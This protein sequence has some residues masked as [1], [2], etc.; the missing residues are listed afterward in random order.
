VLA[1]LVT[2]IPASALGKTHSL[3]P[4]VSIVPSG[5]KLAVHIA[6]QPQAGCKL[7]A[8]AKHKSAT[9]PVVYATRRGKAVIVWTVPTDAPSGN[10]VFRVACKKGR[11]THRTTVKLL[12]INH[13]RGHGSLLVPGSGE[14]GQGT[15]GL[16]GKGGGSGQT[17][18]PDLNG[19]TVCF[20]NDPFGYYQGGTD[21]GECTWYAAGRRADLDGI[22]TGNAADWLN[23]ARGK[24]PEGTTP[25]A[26]AI[27]VWTYGAGGA[28]HVAYVTNVLNGGATVV[29]DESNYARF[30]TV[31]YGR[32]VAAGQISG[33]IYGGPAGTGPGT[34]GGTGPGTGGGTGPS[35]GGTGPSGGGGTPSGNVG[36]TGTPATL[37]DPAGEEAYY[38]GAN[39]DLTEAAWTG[40]NLKVL[41]LGHQMQG[42]PAVFYDP[43]NGQEEIYYEGANGDLD[44]SYWKSGNLSFLDLGVQTTASPA[45]MYDGIEEVYF[46]GTNGD[47]MEFAWG[48][49]SNP[50]DLGHQ[51]QGTPAVFYDS[52]NG[53]EEIYYEGANGDL[54]MSYWKSGNLGF[55]D[56]GQQTTSSPAA[57]YDSGDGLE[58][59]WFR[60][61][62][63]DLT[64]GYWSSSGYKYLDLG[65]AVSQ[66][67]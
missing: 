16:G 58:E 47:L 56:L 17:C 53:Q 55:L 65:S 2:A 44:M 29:V 8:S 64:E 31:S 50:L 38:R 23:E 15:L 49:P 18:A 10:W 9:F 25:V 52:A 33:Y 48:A 5:Q 39:G 35:G 7:S 28:G 20:A 24:V 66:P 32:Q 45:A 14:L 30:H 40:G 27:A 1:I 62:N 12:L 63:G 4:L 34:G 61:A 11:T 19:G 3:R 6:T 43:A 42:T 67:Q 60:G 51:M 26:G 36:L 57:L 41:D 13:G 37:Y 22:V 21:V 59:T 54:D 46:R